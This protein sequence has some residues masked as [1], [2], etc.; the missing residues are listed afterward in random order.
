MRYKINDK[1]ALDS[2]K[3]N[4][5]LIETITPKTKKPYTK[6]SYHRSLKQLSKALLD[7][8]AKETLTRLSITTSKNA[9]T[10]K[11]YNLLMDNIVKDLE[12]F[13]QGAL[14]N[15]KI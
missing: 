1:Y 15:E 9:P 7:G 12:L 13:L 3:Y 8:M 4:W 6:Q 11:P 10:T 5:I 14:T 2:D